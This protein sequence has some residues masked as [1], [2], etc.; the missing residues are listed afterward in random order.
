[1]LERATRPAGG[2]A[3]SLLEADSGQPRLL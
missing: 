2:R 3:S 1:M